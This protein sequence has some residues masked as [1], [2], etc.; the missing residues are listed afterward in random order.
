M[1]TSI[2]AR[3]ALVTG[4]GRGIGRAISLKLADAGM[5]VVVNDLQQQVIDDVV[6][7]I[8]ARGGEAVGVPGSVRDPE[9]PATFMRTATERF[10]RIDVLVNNAGFATYAPAA[11]CLN[12]D[13]DLVVD[14]LVSAPFRIL[15]PF[16]TY[17]KET[18]ASSGAVPRNVIN[19]ASIAG[20]RGST[21]QAAYGAGKAA[22]I[23]LTRTL[24]RE[25]GDLNVTINAICPGPTRTR[26]TEVEQPMQD[27]IEV[28]GRSIKLR[29]LTTSWEDYNK[30]IPLGRPATPED[31]AG[32]VYLLTLPEARYIHGQAIVVDGGL[33]A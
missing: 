2:N 15:K 20:F 23:N 24:A 16:H 18:A 28:E 33:T 22:V 30:M 7:E 31:I 26:L 1:N 25:W 14:V 4:G 8:K 9:F 19:I 29:G 13:W 3:V 5:R 27:Q 17:L 11:D 6:A 12:E 32:G 10:G 21:G